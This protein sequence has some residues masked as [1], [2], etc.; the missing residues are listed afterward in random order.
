MKVYTG[1]KSEG[2]NLPKALQAYILGMSNMMKFLHGTTFSVSICAT[3]KCM[4]TI[5]C[6]LTVLYAHECL[7]SE[8]YLCNY[9]IIKGPILN[10]GSTCSWHAAPAMV[11][12]NVPS[13]L[14]WASLVLHT[15]N[16]RHKSKKTQK[17]Q[18][19]QHGYSM[20]RLQCLPPCS[21]QRWPFQGCC[22][23]WHW[24]SFGW[25]AS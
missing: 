25:A 14:T 22:S 17:Q 3:S 19:T 7:H 8:N 23:A 16:S 9:Y 10:Q 6:S 4:C 18:G 13:G 1:R 15:L 20:G 5:S 21:I 12:A 24:D 11:I 2:V